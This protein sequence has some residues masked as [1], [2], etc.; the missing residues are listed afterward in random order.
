[1]LPIAFPIA[2]WL[3]V[4]EMKKQKTIRPILLK[5]RFSDNL[6]VKLFDKDGKQKDIF[7][8]NSLGK[9]LYRFGIKKEHLWLGDYKRELN[10]SNILTNDAFAFMAS[11]IGGDGAEAIA[12]YIALG[13]GTNA[14]AVTDTTL[15][16]E[17]SATGLAR[18]AATISRVTTTETDDTARALKLFTNASG[19][20]IAVTEYGLLNAAAAG[21][22]VGRKVEAAVSVADGDGIQVTYDVKASA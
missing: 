10:F 22:L 15:Q 14:A 8:M 18:A 16:T 4:K 3:T 12:N 1:M 20:P 21:V 11:R 19:G 6:N 13:T 7:R 17:T 9:I 5:A 2:V